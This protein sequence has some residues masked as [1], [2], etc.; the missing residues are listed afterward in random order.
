MKLIIPKISS[1][2]C[3][4][5]EK[6]S[7]INKK[8]RWHIGSSAEDL[9]RGYYIHLQR[10]SWWFWVDLYQ[11]DQHF[12]I[13]ERDASFDAFVKRVIHELDNVEPYTK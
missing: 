5:L 1:S 13:Q 12:Y 2:K 6:V 7:Y 8:L 4:L 3:N 10:K 9:F 11:V